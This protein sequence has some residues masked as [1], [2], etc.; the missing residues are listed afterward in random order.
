[1]RFWS[2]IVEF[3]VQ[4]LC[5]ASVLDSVLRMQSTWCE[6]QHLHQYH[7]QGRCHVSGEGLR[8][9]KG[10]GECLRLEDT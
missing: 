8:S 5:N 4:R 6:I 7:H 3:C 1:M 10:T 2:G 9:R